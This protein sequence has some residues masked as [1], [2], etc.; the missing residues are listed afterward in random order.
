MLSPE[1]IV[2]LDKVLRVP[3]DEFLKFLHPEEE[4]VAI[5]SPARRI[6]LARKCLGLLNTITRATFDGEDL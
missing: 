4:G 2:Q 1:N 6:L 3:K 5:D